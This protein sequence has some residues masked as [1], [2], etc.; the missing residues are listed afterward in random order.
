[1]A[2]E[3][4]SLKNAKR[5]YQAGLW[6]TVVAAIC[7]FTPLLVIALG[8]LGLAA[9]IP[10]LDRVLFPLLGICLILAAYGWWRMKQCREESNAMK[11]VK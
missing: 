4:N 1:M 11:N 10:Y 7:S 6:G 5:C 8:F 3:N 2:T 9:V